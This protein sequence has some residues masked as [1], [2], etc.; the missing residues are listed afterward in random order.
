MRVDVFTIFPDAVDQFSAVGLLGKLLFLAGFI[1]PA[2][3]PFAAVA[4]YGGSVLV[5]VSYVLS[6]VPIRALGAVEDDAPGAR[7]LFSGDDLDQ[8]RLA[9]AVVAEERHHLAGG[10]GEGH[11]AQRLDRAEALADLGELEERQGGHGFQGFAGSMRV[12]GPCRKGYLRGELPDARGGRTS[13]R[14]R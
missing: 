11:S 13:T 10:H 2:T 12:A 3:A 4:A 7:A 8:R 1:A 5:L 9:G 14:R 6:L